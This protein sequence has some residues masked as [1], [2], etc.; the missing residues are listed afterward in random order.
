MEMN[1][2]VITINNQRYMAIIHSEDVIE[3][4]SKEFRRTYRDLFNA[5][6]AQYQDQEPLKEVS[7]M[8]FQ[9][10]RMVEFNAQARTA[11]KAFVKAL[12]TI[13]PEVKV[14]KLPSVV[15]HELEICKRV[16]A[17]FEEEQPEAELDKEEINMMRLLKYHTLAQG[18]NDLK[19]RIQLGACI[20]FSSL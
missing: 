13:N 5:V 10:S 14:T 4:T 15:G 6:V 19:E 1:I 16:L 7:E 11:W 2:G 8:G 17:K 18:K 3:N 9:A 12:A 20:N